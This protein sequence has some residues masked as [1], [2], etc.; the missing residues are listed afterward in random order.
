MM[1]RAGTGGSIFRN[2]YRDFLS[3]S[4]EIIKNAEI[5]KGYN[6]FSIIA[7]QWNEIASLIEESSKT[8]DEKYL[9]QAAGLCKS[10]AQRETD[11]MK[12]LVSL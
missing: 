11:A 2:F 8:L 6:A 9:V 3:E 7:D 12:I 5:K 4:C 1:E 10:L